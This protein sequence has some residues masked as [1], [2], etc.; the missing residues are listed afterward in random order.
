MH[1]AG[2]AAWWLPRWLDRIMP[3][4]DVEGSA[5]ERDHARRPTGAEESGAEESGDLEEQREDGVGS[6]RR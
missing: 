2:D 1:L 5:L 6:G 3:D 4:I